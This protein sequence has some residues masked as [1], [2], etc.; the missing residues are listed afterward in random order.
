MRLSALSRPGVIPL[1]AAVTSPD[2][3]VPANSRRKCG[4]FPSL[5][6]GPYTRWFHRW[7]LLAG[8]AAAMIYGTVVA[9]RQPVARLGRLPR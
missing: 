2:P 9:C 8:R 7:A 5:V 6:A 3:A 4:T 1:S